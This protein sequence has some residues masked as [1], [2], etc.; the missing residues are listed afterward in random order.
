MKTIFLFLIGSLILSVSKV[1]AQVDPALANALQEVLDNRVQNSGDHGVSACVILQNGDIWKG[2]AGVGAGN[3]A[4]SDSTVFHG[5]STAKFNIAILMLLLDEEGLIDLDASWDDY[6]DLNV[7]FSPEITIRQLISNTSGIADYL[8]VPGSGNYV[9]DDFFHSFTPQEI[10]EQIV[11]GTP[12]FAPGTDFWYSSSN[13][14]LA[15]LIAETVTG[16]PVQEELR[17]RIWEPLGMTHTYFGGFEEYAEPRAGVWW[18]FGDGLTN[19][20]NEPEISMLTYAYGCANIVSTPG[21]LAILVGSILSGSILQQESLDEMLVFSPDSFDDWSNGYGLG[22]HN[23]YAFANYTA[24]GH[25][26]YYTNMT[27]MFYS[28]EH[29]FSLVT[30]T[31]TQTTWFAIFTE[32]YEIIEEHILSNIENPN[33]LE[34]LQLYPNPVRDVLTIHSEMFSSG[35]LHCDIYD[36]SGKLVLTYATKAVHN[37]LRVD[38]TSLLPG[39]YSLQLRNEGTFIGRQI[40]TRE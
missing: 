12:D 27:D 18:N 16:N 35:L 8:E 34:E 2:T 5:A 13:F 24:V 6:I 20:S 11:S 9:T 17:T 7:D 29:H 33:G 36:T 25:D 10:L 40:F 32:M 30:M 28:L 15:A 1:E 26:G 22:I 3:I 14:V 39:I 31:N 23:P 19:Y 37:N 4:I 21:D 38:V